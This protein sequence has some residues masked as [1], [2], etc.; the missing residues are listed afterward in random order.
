MTEVELSAIRERDTKAMAIADAVMKAF[1]NAVLTEI[2]FQ[3]ALDRAALL[4]HI[5]ADR[6]VPVAE[7]LPRSTHPIDVVLITF[8]TGTLTDT[9]NQLAYCY[10]GAWCWVGSGK[11]VQYP[12]VAWHP[13]PA[14][15]APKEQKR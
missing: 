13:L 3:D 1:P 4:A 6:W 12:V 5:D 7:R 2:G 11:P 15:Y 8:S 10:N 9:A 14:P